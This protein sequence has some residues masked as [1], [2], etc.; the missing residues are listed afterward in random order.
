MGIA[1]PTL[2]RRGNAPP[3]R[4]PVPGGPRGVRALGDPQIPPPA[5][6][7]SRDDGEGG[8]VRRDEADGA[9]LRR[10]PAPRDPGGAHAHELRPLRADLDRREP[11]DRTA[12]LA[13]RAW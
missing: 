3:S 1:S 10:E 6:E 8:F 11:R 9:Q 2:P 7:A 12:R 13:A 5:G 4:P